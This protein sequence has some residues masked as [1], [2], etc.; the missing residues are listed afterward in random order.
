MLPKVISSIAFWFLLVE[1]AHSSQ[2]LLSDASPVAPSAL[3]VPPPPKVMNRGVARI[4]KLLHKKEVKEQ[5]DLAEEKQQKINIEKETQRKEQVLQK[6]LHAS[7]KPTSYTKAGCFKLSKVHQKLEYTG[8]RDVSVDVCFNFCQ[9]KHDKNPPM[10][11]F[12]VQNGNQCFCANLHEG[13]PMEKCDKP[14]AGD[15]EMKCGG[16]ETADMYVMYDCTPPTPEEIAA[17]KKKAEAKVLNGYAVHE[18]QSCGKSDSNAFTIDG[19]PTFVGSVDECKHK[20]SSALEC[21]GFTYE[22]SLTRCLFHKDVSSG[23]V[24]KG[25]KI[26]CFY[27]NP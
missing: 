9:T 26:D 5:A 24:K 14:C 1:A 21:H 19:S 15:A 8:S 16:A 27:K 20:C 11:V 4:Y 10:Q 18:K 25:K 7:G 13:E 22:K 2:V 6:K 23:K 3:G 12:G 17:A